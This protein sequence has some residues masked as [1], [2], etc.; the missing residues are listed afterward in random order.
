MSAASAKITASDPY[1]LRRRA[2]GSAVARRIHFWMIPGSAPPRRSGINGNRAV[3]WASR[4]HRRQRVGRGL[5]LRVPLGH[6]QAASAGPSVDHSKSCDAWPTPVRLIT[7]A[8][9]QN[10][11]PRSGD[12]FSARHKSTQVLQ[13]P[14]EHEWVG[15]D[16]DFHRD[17]PRLA[18]RVRPLHPSHQVADPVRL[19]GERQ[20]AQCP[21]SRGTGGRPA[22]S[23]APSPTRLSGRSAR[24]IGRPGR[25][26]WFQ[27]SLSG[28]ARSTGRGP[29]PAGRGRTW[30][31]REKNINSCSDPCWAICGPLSPSIFV[32]IAAV[33]L[34]VC[35]NTSIWCLMTASPVGPRGVRMVE[36]GHGRHRHR[37]HQRPRLHLPLGVPDPAGRPLGHV[38]PDQLAAVLVL[39]AEPPVLERLDVDGRHAQLPPRPGRAV[40]MVE[41]P[42][43]HVRVGDELLGRRHGRQRRVLHHLGKGVARRR[44][45]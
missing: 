5:L 24:S 16:L 22:G 3:D 32:T 35:R 20:A 44:R 10:R 21:A 30:P 33:L 7:A 18:G 17:Q 29:S 23:A 40:R 9:S 26:G 31:S 39:P 25:S 45:H 6:A 43:V 8:A 36:H 12:G 4:R 28:P 15:L 14:A 1:S 11:S 19:A 42:L 2:S 41:Q 13:Q 34:S 38:L 37:R 27:P